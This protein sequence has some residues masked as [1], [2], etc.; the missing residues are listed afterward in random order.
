MKIWV[1][2]ILLAVVFYGCE[3]TISFDLDEADTVLVVDG[4][5]ENG[6]PPL[7]ILSNSFNYFSEITT[8]LL[9]KSFIH[10]AVITLSNG[11]RTTKLK[12]Y[13]FTNDSNTRIY[14]YSIDSSNLSTAILGELANSI[15]WTSAWVENLIVR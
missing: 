1:V 9:E 14:F 13:S 6:Q 5:I 10:D 11:S 12:E 3:K 2:F 7:I 8:D 4:S 15:P